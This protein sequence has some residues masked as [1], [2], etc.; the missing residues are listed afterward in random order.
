MDTLLV[1][2][3]GAFPCPGTVD[4]PGLPSAQ[5]LPKFEGRDV[6]QVMADGAFPWM[7]RVRAKPCLYLVEP[8]LQ[9]GECDLVTPTNPKLINPGDT[10]AA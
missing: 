4:Q 8:A 2:Q 1:C 5:N 6:L 3:P 9:W 10:G 7:E